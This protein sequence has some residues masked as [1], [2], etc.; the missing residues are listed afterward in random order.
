MFVGNRECLVNP[1]AEWAMYFIQTFIMVMHPTY[2]DI[3]VRSIGGGSRGA[4]APLK[5]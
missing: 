3:S 4:M 5:F 2:F 1:R